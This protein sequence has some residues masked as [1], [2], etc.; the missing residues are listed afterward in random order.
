L[1]GLTKNKKGGKIMKDR[2]R[3]VALLLSVVFVLVALSAC[4]GG[5]DSGGN[6]GTNGGTNG[7]GNGGGNGGT[8]GG[9]D[10]GNFPD[11]GGYEFTIATFHIEELAPTEDL[12]DPMPAARLEA[13]ERIE[14]DYNV[15]IKG[16][17]LSPSEVFD[18]LQPAVIAGD[19]FV[20]ALIT[21]CWAYGPLLGAGVLLD[22]NQISTLNLDADWWLDAVTETLTIDGKVM[23]TMG[24][25]THPT[26]PTYNFHFNWNIWE[27][28]DFE[29]P[30]ELVRKGEWTWDKMMDFGVRASKSQCGSGLVDCP[31]DRW[32][33][34]H[35]GEDFDRAFFFSMGERIYGADPETGRIR[36]ACATPTAYEKIELMGRFINTPGL[37]YRGATNWT[38]ARQFFV[39]G[40]A[41]FIS[42]QV[43]SDFTDMENNFGILPMPKW[44]AAQPFYIGGMDHNSKVLGVP[45]TNKDKDRENTGIIL[46]ALGKAWMEIDR[47]MLEDYEFAN[48]RNDEDGEMLMEYIYG[49]T[50]VDLVLFLKS[51]NVNL[52]QPMA[53]IVS[54]MGAG[55]PS[56][57][58]ASEMESIHDLINGLLDE[59]FNY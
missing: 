30:Y 18:Q 45:V 17:D 51:A 34:L 1:Q 22:L 29:N 36:M 4:G 26:G 46:D 8:N 20:N 27:E 14:R 40:K 54:A 52:G 33:F 11:L 49:T 59:F 37:A 53:V 41:L 58:I 38:E 19:M 50:Y 35:N 28:M 56:S 43:T 31:E 42:S 47:L 39:D 44:N 5:N 55:I 13:L 12:S 57:D 3:I 24:S 2:K 23:G 7:G 16:M 6:G 21:T 15:I 32:G 25:L 10:T 9:G 48:Y